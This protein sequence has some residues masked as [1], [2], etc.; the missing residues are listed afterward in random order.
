LL[1]PEAQ[2]T[3]VQKLVK[4]SPRLGFS[5]ILQLTGVHGSQQFDK[6]TRTKTVETILT[7]MD[8]TAIK[9]YIDH[10]L[11]QVNDDQYV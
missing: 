2:A 8:T 10:L 7:S 4:N 6:L 3:D 5:L 11:R 9:Q 1:I